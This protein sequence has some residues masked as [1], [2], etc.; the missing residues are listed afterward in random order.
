MKRQLFIA[1]ALTGTLALAGCDQADDSEQSAADTATQTEQTTGSEQASQ[2]GEQQASKTLEGVLE[3][4]ATDTPLPDDARVTVS[5]LDVARADAPATTISETMVD[6]TGSDP[7][8]FS[9]D[10]PTDQVDPGHAHAL[11]AEIRDADGNLLWTSP[12]RHQVEVGPDAEQAPI[13]VSLEPVES[14]GSIAGQALEDTENAV[15]QAGDAAADTADDAMDAAGDAADATQDAAGDAV[16]ATQDA[17]ADVAEATEDAAD[18]A[19]EEVDEMTED[20]AQSS[21]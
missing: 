14:Q 21:Q 16:D 9:L 8:E 15:D 20:D 3:F 4:V 13:T 12:Q 11:R 1:A 6:V 17:A 18:S 19:A 7:V 5:L 10:Y 2:D